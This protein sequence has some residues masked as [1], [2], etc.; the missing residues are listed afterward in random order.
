M[1][2]RLSKETQEHFAKQ[3]Q[4]IK[5]KALLEAHAFL[6]WVVEQAPPG[7]WNTCTVLSKGKWGDVQANLIFT[8]GYG[9]ER[10]FKDDLPETI[11]AFAPAFMPDMQGTLALVS[12]TPQGGSFDVQAREA[13]DLVS[14]MSWSLADTQVSAQESN[15]EMGD[16]GIAYGVPAPQYTLEASQRAQDR[17]LG[18]N[19]E[20]DHQRAIEAL[21]EVVKSAEEGKHQLVLDSVHLEGKVDT[22]SLNFIK[23]EG[24]LTLGTQFEEFAAEL[25][26]VIGNGV[27]LP[28]YL[29]D[30]WEAPQ[31]EGDQIEGYLRLWQVTDEGLVPADEESL[32]MVA[33]HLST[34]ERKVHVAPSV[35]PYTFSQGV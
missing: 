27:K 23:G 26:A 29:Y 12:F 8:R 18:R 35:L 4:E 5:D 25:T 24:D 31:E 7:T 28:S 6:T 21:V 15:D 16:A 9:K 22:A 30:V 10:A 3:N 33:E 11:R 1:S 20:R 17:V 13:L 19:T 2:K 14:V 32:S 34:P